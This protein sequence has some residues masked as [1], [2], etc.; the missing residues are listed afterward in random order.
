L[1][2]FVKKK[3]LYFSDLRWEGNSL[4]RYK[5]KGVKIKKARGVDC[6]ESV[7]LSTVTFYELIKF[8]G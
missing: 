3:E 8:P 5:N 4:K 7:N 1:F 2:S 6:F